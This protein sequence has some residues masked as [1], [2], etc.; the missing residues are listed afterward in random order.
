MRTL[1]ALPGHVTASLRD[2]C[3]AAHHDQ[4]GRQS[5]AVLADLQTSSKSPQQSRM[6]VDN[7]PVCITSAR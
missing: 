6:V 3:T 4:H 1:G 7:G 5:Q 2:H